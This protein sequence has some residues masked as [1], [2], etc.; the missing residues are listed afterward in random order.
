MI[1][2]VKAWVVTIRGRGKSLDVISV[3]KHKDFFLAEDYREGS[4]GVVYKEKRNS[5]MP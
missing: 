4:S 3:D 1:L 5:D 2:E